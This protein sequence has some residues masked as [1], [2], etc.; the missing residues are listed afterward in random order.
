MTFDTCEYLWNASSFNEAAVFDKLG[1][2]IFSEKYTA[3]TERT[4]T[5]VI[6]MSVL[7][8]DCELTDI[9]SGDMAAI[10]PY[11]TFSST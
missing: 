5:S 3:C 4:V 1:M 11:I 10:R 8:I 9:D 7:K 2:R 6:V